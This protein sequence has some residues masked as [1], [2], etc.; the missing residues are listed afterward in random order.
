[1]KAPCFALLAALCAVVSGCGSQMTDGGYTNNS[2]TVTGTVNFSEPQLLPVDSVVTIQVVDLSNASLPKIYGEEQI[3]N[4]GPSPVPFHI[5]FQAD[6][7]AM[8]NGLNLQARISYDGKLQLL[9]KTQ[10]DVK[11]STLGEAHQIY[12]GQTQ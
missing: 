4:P 11:L 10:Y 9:N 2:R 6:D 3:K 8:I 1:M 7:Q 5:E 12:V